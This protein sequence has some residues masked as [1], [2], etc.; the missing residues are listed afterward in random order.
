MTWLIIALVYCAHLCVILRLPV[1]ATAMNCCAGWWA[2]ALSCTVIRGPQNIPCSANKAL[3][4]Q[5][6][7][8]SSTHTFYQDQTRAEWNYIIIW[9]SC[10][11]NHSQLCVFPKKDGKRAEVKTLFFEGAVGGREWSSGTCVLGLGKK[12]Y[13][14][15]EYLFLSSVSDFPRRHVHN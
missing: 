13:N 6:S 11:H 2:C 12:H 10:H 7:S 5:S 15:T 3:A 4:K 8:S 14:I 1:V 9:P